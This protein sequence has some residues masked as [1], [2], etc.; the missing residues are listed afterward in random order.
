MQSTLDLTPPRVTS[1]V[2]TTPPPKTVGEFLG[3]QFKATMAELA[4]LF[5]KLPAHMQDQARQAHSHVQTL[6]RAGHYDQAAGLVDH[7][8]KVMLELV[9]AGKEGSF[10]LSETTKESNLETDHVVPTLAIPPL[11]TDESASMT[12]LRRTVEDLEM[13]MKDNAAISLIAKRV[14]D[15]ELEQRYNTLEQQLR[16]VKRVVEEKVGRIR[17]LSE[18]TER[19]AKIQVKKRTVSRNPFCQHGPTGYCEFCV[20]KDMS[21]EEEGFMVSSRATSKSLLPIPTNSAGVSAEN[22]TNR[23]IISK[24]QDTLKS[25]QGILKELLEE[26]KQQMSKSST[27]E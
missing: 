25:Y 20:G 4:A 2:D 24:M 3:P 12:Q 1:L 13:K 14:R 19:L 23:E 18:E 9:T 22:N 26:R 11:P 27:R 21:P 10:E 17:Q 6:I 15:M 7:M 5:P 8:K 16:E